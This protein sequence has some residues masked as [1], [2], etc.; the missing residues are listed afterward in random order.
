M[1]FKYLSGKDAALA[2]LITEHAISAPAYDTRNMTC[3]QRVTRPLLEIICIAETKATIYNALEKLCHPDVV[4]PYSVRTT[5]IQQLINIGVA[6]E[7]GAMGILYVAKIFEEA[8]IDKMNT[9]LSD[10]VSDENL[11]HQ[12]RHVAALKPYMAFTVLLFGFQR[13]NYWPAHEMEFKE[14]Y[15]AFNKWLQRWSCS[16]ETLA[17]LESWEPYK[18]LAA[19]IIWTHA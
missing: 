12:L 19:W 9:L 17:A 1:G 11:F 7:S 5:S 16:D 13:L 14:K 10:D 8:G 6:S 3:F 18:G 2:A 15:D 4:R